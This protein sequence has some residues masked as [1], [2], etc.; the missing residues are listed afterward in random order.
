MKKISIFLI[1]CLIQFSEGLTCIEGFTLVNNK[2]LKLIIT[3]QTH[4]AARRE[5]NLNGGNL[6]SVYNAIDNTAIAQFATVGS[7]P[8]WIGLNCPNDHDASSCVWDN[9]A[10]N[11]SGYNNFIAANPSNDVGTCV[12]MLTFGS[13]RGRWFSASCDGME[14]SAVCETSPVEQCLY[15]LNGYCYYPLGEL[16][17]VDAQNACSQNCEGS[18][19]SIHSAAENTF[20]SKIFKDSSKGYIRIGAQL[21]SGNVNSWID[22][23]VWDYTNIGYQNKGLGSCYSMSL[24]NELV[25]PGKWISSNCSALLPSVCKRPQHAQCGSTPAPTLAP[26]QCSG[27]SYSTDTGA[28]YSP[29]Y[30]YSYLSTDTAPCYY[31][32]TVTTDTAMIWFTEVNLD[33]N[34]RIELY[35]SLDTQTPFAI[36]D[37]NS[38]G[39]IT[40][41]TFESSTSLIKMVFKPCTTCGS[42]SSGTI[43]RWKAILG[44][45]YPTL[46]ASDQTISTNGIITSTNYPNVYNNYLSCPYNLQNPNKGG[47]IQLHFTDFWTE[48]GYDYVKIYDG[49]NSTQP[50]LASISGNL[51]GNSNLTYTSTGQNLYVLFT[52]DRSNVFKGFSAVFYEYP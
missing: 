28:I 36:I 6:V 50:L 9:Q 22:G 5:C 39:N 16:S 45:Q 2:C 10:G 34:A 37:R 40:F 29:N 49:R 35:S 4:S 12:Y 30:P 44:K 52:S 13:L 21:S 7:D 18:L 24:I 51:V 43:F 25:V 11:A 14:I 17:E 31:I 42:S 41:S 47:R 46:C 3:D 48:S 27:I 38:Q 20:V 19:V 33:A 26:P 23:S 32:L 15:N 8:V 1:F